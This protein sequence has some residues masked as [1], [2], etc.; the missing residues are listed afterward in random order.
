[1][2]NIM[3]FVDIYLYVYIYIYLSLL[4]LDCISFGE[5][6]THIPVVSPWENH[7]EISTQSVVHFETDRGLEFS[8]LHL[9]FPP[10]KSSKITQKSPRNRP[11]T[12]EITEFSRKSPRAREPGD[13]GWWPPGLPCGGLGLAATAGRGP[14][15][16]DRFLKQNMRNTWAV[17]KSHHLSVIPPVFCDTF[18]G[19]IGH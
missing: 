12:R 2:L 14:R 7:H 6:K 18:W 8:P 3:V 17:L 11:E 15:D 5:N 4:Y 10:E 9:Q 16:G 13:Q 1:M 19:F